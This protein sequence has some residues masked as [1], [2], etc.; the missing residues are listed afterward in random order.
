M[1]SRGDYQ[2]MHGEDGNERKEKTTTSASQEELA[3][4]MDQSRVFCRL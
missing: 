4:A 1:A 3:K 2:A